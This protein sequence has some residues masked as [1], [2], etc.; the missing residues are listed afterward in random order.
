M[1]VLIVANYNPGH[2]SPFVVEQVKALQEIG[3]E[4]DFFGIV[5]K[6]F[7]GYLK[8]LPRLKQKI[9]EYKP[10]IVHAHYGLSSLL[11]NLQRIVP[12]VTTFHGSDIHSQGMIL[13]LSK[14]A[15]KLSAYNIFVTEILLKISQYK[16]KNFSIVP[17]G[18]DSKRF[19]Q[20]DKNVAR[21]KLGWNKEKTYILFAGA[22]SNAVKNAPLAKE[23]VA[24]L[25]DAELVE[26]QGFS[27]QEVVYVMNASD[28][29]LMTSH[30]EG[31]P[32][33]IKE[34]MACGTP[35]VSVD[36]GDV[37]NVT[38][39]IAGCYIASKNA[40]NITSKLKSALTFDKRTDGRNRIM[41]L[42]LTN[43]LVA[44]KILDIYKKVTGGK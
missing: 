36:V 12:V 29:L 2:F 34:A 4:I 18:I 41:E 35:I 1:K 6:G 30:G 42:G 24:K 31:S 11:A 23:A 43:D 27:R 39:N 17:C 26:M 38:S 25:N 20:I 28:C 10:D 33:V 7:I 15:M 32:M 5:G 13:M 40:E 8:N 3:C 44:K 21:A 14:I 22:Y 16:K 37:K 9:K 19:I